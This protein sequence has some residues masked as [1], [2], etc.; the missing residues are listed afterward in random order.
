MLKKQL[1]WALMVELAIVCSVNAQALRMTPPIVELLTTPSSTQSFYVTLS[2]D[3]ESAV[4]CRMEIKSMALTELGMPVPVDSADRSSAAW[5]TI[6][7]E[8]SFQLQPT[9]TKPIQFTIRPPLRIEPGGY[10]CMISARATNPQQVIGDATQARAAIRIQYQMTSVVMLIVKG[11]NVQAKIQP[12]APMIYGGNRAGAEADRNWY[13]QVPV[14]NDGNLHI[15]LEGDVQIRSEAG[16]L[17]RQQGLIAGRGYLMPGQRRL[18]KAEGKGPL[19]DGV[20]VADVRIGRFD[21]QQAATERIPFYI[22]RGQ[23][24]PGRPDNA[25]SQTLEETAQGFILDKMNLRIEAAAGGRRTQMVQIINVTDR[26][27]VVQSSVLPWDQDANGDVTFPK[28]TKHGKDLAGQVT[29]TPASFTLKPKGKMNVKILFNIAKASQGE[30]FGCILF[31][32]QGTQ[33]SEFAPLLM[34]QSVLASV[35]VNKTESPD[36]K[37]EQF[38]AKPIKDK[39]M[40]LQTSIK[41]TGNIMIYPQGRISIFDAENVRISDPI[42]FGQESFILP[43]NERM[44]TIEWNRILPPGRY[45][46]EVTLEYDINVNP[47]KE[48]FRFTL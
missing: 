30:Y 14:R 13:V 11:P 37:F 27:Y 48:E 47:L 21:V 5:V 12:E 38:V 46:A 29:V 2:N 31:Q 8:S 24:Y 6:L 22:L 19:P 9:E 26:E 33:L 16:Q 3:G 18:F 23:V 20:Y 35:K 28:Q 42:A 44:F 15:A 43:N 10:Y 17:V 40:T 7:G 1:F 25:E 39:G 45:R 41:N 4:D 32:R 36:A 34:S